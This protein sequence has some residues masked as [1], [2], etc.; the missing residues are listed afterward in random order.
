MNIPTPCPTC[1]ELRKEY[2]AL[3]A[4]AINSA[5]SNLECSGAILTLVKEREEL[6]AVVRCLVDAAKGVLWVDECRCRDAWTGRDMHEPNS[7]CGELDPLREALA[8]VAGELERMG[9]KV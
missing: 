9:V 6:E 3:T 4:L 8:R 5:K 7:K 1:E 2:G